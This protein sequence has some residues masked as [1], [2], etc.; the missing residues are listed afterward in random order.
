MDGHTYWDNCFFFLTKLVHGA[1]LDDCVYF[2]HTV[3]ASITHKTA[4]MKICFRKE[5]RLSTIKN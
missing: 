1:V 3:S 2:F 4:W 5:G